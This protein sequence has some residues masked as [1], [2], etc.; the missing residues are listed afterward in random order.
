[1]KRNEKK[2]VIL[3]DTSYE[4]H[5]GCKAVMGNIRRLLRRRNINIIYANPVSMNWK[6]NERFIKNIKNSDIAII[7]G[8]GTIHHSQR[9]GLYLVK[10]SEYCK[11]LGL[12]V[13]LINSSYCK[14][15]EEF[16][17]YMKNFDLI[18]VRE[19]LSQNELRKWG[20]DS[21]VVPDM[22]F[23]NTVNVSEK[24][25]TSRIGFTDSFFIELSEKLYKYTQESEKYLYL[26][27]LMSYR[28]EKWNSLKAILKKLK[29]EG[30][31]TVSFFQK[32]LLKKK[33]NHV[34][35]RRFYYVRSYDEYIKTIS[36]LK[37]LVTG[38]F[39]SL[40]F[41]LKTQTPFLALH[42]NFHKIEGI[43]KDIGL[44]N[45]RI[46][47]I[48][49]LNEETIAHYAYFSKDELTKIIAYTNSAITKIERMFGKI[50][51]LIK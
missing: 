33:L 6:K 27:I 17:N 41:A 29:F 32:I 16:A 21:E 23:Y 8:E 48:E 49:D 42:L 38:R 37:L 1:M 19:S 44:S 31:N 45:E 20:I 34:Y 11:K 7:N 5:H 12:P 51:G 50:E 25:V 43:L 28:I 10:V 26:P 36:D 9:T 46:I 13:V 47:N 24:K 40:C 30:R 39:H 18:F 3:N 2:A 35:K 22:T 4:L 15:N 14:N